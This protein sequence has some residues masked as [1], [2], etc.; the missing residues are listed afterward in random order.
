F[1]VAVD[2]DGARFSRRVSVAR[3]GQWS[4][5]ADIYRHGLASCAW[6]GA[7]ARTGLDGRR[8][9]PRTRS[10]AEHRSNSVAERVFR[11]GDPAYRRVFG[12]V[13]SR[14]WRGIYRRRGAGDGGGDFGLAPES[15]ER[16]SGGNS[17]SAVARTSVPDARK[18]ALLII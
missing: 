14:L 13:E 9:Q 2:D 11:S 16:G 1:P 12:A 6:P 5:H 8:G 3:A 17:G 10:G 18:R 4:G 15:A 7:R